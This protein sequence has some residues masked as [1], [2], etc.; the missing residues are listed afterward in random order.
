MDEKTT[1]QELLGRVGQKD[2]KSLKVLMDRYS[3]YVAAV[4]VHVSGNKLPYQ[5]VEEI[6]SDVF[7]K[8]WENSARIVPECD[9]LKP[10]L[11]AAARNMTINMLKRLHDFTDI[12][13]LEIGSGKDDM[14]AVVFEN[15]VNT[16]VCTLK[17]PDR[18]L[19]VDRYFYSWPLK[20][21]AEKFG[22]NRNTVATK[23][24]RARKTVAKKLKEGEEIL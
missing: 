22:L 16:A 24:L 18:E 6:C 4:I 7:I 23:L 13:D 15:S 1:D 17:Q 9:T 20:E 8:I 12:Q 3:R 14:E 21:L 5:D 10:Y 2:G 11:A 19:F